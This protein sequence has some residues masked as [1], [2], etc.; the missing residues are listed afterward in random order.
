M[1]NAGPTTAL[2]KG[3][4]VNSNTFSGSSRSLPGSA[5]LRLPS[6][7]GST[8]GLCE[9]DDVLSIGVSSDRVDLS[10]DDFAYLERLGDALR[11]HVVATYENH[12]YQNRSQVNPEQWKLVKKKDGLAAYKQRKRV[13]VADLPVEGISDPRG[14]FVSD[15]PPLKVVGSIAGIVDDLMY[16]LV[17]STTKSMH[18]KSSYCQDGMD[19]GR[20]LV[21][22]RAPTVEEPYRFMGVKWVDVNYSNANGVSC[23]SFAKNRDLLYLENM[24][25]T[26]LSTGIKIGFHMAHS[27]N[28]ESVAS[29]VMCA[30]GSRIRAKVSKVKI[31]R[32][33]S[34]G[35]TI[36]AYMRGKYDPCGDMMKFMGT[37]LAVDLLLQIVPS[38]LR[39]GHHKKLAWI[40][41]QS[42]RRRRAQTE[43]QRMTANCLDAAESE[44]NY[45]EQD[46]V[47]EMCGHK[48]G[49]V[50]QRSGAACTTCSK[51]VCSRC[52]MMKKLSFV[53]NM[54]DDFMQSS[55]SLESDQSVVSTRASMKEIVQK[56]LRF[57]LPCVLA[58]TQQ[59][60][61]EIAVEEVLELTIDTVQ[62]HAMPSSRR[63]RAV[64]SGSTQGLQYA[65]N[66]AAS[67]RPKALSTT[68]TAT[69]SAPSVMLYVEEDVKP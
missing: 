1:A 68:S 25:V 19:S 30:N 66:F 36:D 46:P 26:T 69:S 64:R 43:T 21:T 52:S 6:M 38:T 24:G 62:P 2:G 12:V 45:H 59:R 35:R 60:A 23:S 7:I 11:E 13:A 57:C 14:Q 55:G 37:S 47:C 58:A 18:L 53:Q 27:I 16:G 15:L 65:A 22:I 67:V 33:R 49:N 5:R 8:S 41:Q 51:R 9:S 28:I 61:S 63:G 42:S 44:V 48:Y 34:D 40:A 39:C 10:D 29:R 4:F 56:S 32:Q 20:V 50:L 17:S 31:F 3:A 54:D